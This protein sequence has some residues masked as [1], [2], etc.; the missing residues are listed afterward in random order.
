MKHCTKHELSSHFVKSTHD[1]FIVT[2]GY[3]SNDKLFSQEVVYL[4]KNKEPYLEYCMVM[5]MGGKLDICYRPIINGKYDS[6]AFESF[7]DAIRN[8]IF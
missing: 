5:E 7:S 4:D 3:S 1:Y 2:N 6:E 8:I